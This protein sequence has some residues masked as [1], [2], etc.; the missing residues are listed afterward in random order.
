MPYLY[1]ATAAVLIAAGLATAYL[2]RRR[3]TSLR[4]EVRAAPIDFAAVVAVK[5]RTLFGDISIRGDMLLRVRGGFIEVSNEFAPARVLLGQ[6]FYLR[7]DVVEVEVGVNS[8]GRECIVISG[9]SSGKNI[10]LTIAERR[11][12]RTIWDALVKAGAK[13]ITQPPGNPQ[14]KEL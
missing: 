4:L 8:W 5:V 3:D 10:V 11:R 7:A 13:P 14:H 2:K 9:V 6:E 1:L 12:I